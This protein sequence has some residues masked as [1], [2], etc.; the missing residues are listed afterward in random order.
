M[1]LLNTVFPSTPAFSEEVRSGYIGFIPSRAKEIEE[2]FTAIGSFYANF[3]E[4]LAW[5]DPTLRDI[6]DYYRSVRI[7]GG[8]KVDSCTDF[9]LRYSVTPFKNE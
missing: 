1:V 4:R 2:D 5:E 9:P 8:V 3:M 7:G 6:V